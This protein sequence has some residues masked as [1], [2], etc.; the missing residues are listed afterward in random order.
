VTQSIK[1]VK[2]LIRLVTV[3]LWLN[4]TTSKY[5]VDEADYPSAF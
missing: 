2:Y 3:P 1:Y 4:V 5:A